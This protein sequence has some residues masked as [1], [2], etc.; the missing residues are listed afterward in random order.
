MSRF[1]WIGL[2]EAAIRLSST[3]DDVESLIND[4]ALRART[5]D[6]VD[7]VVRSDEVDLLAGILGF[8]R[9]TIRGPH[10]RKKSR[11]SPPGN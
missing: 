3:P 5:I 10:M 7:R 2:D 4:G 1:S 6:G 8:N 9:P 11:K